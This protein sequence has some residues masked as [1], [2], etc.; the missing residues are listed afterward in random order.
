MN[1]GS[2]FSGIGGLEL[3]LERAGM[4]TVWQ[5]EVDPYASR[6]LAKHW[7]DVPN[8]GDVARVDWDAVERPDLICGGFPCQP[9]SVAGQRKGKDDER[10][11]WPEFATVPTPLTTTVPMILTE[12]RM[13]AL[14]ADMLA[15][16]G[17][18]QAEFARRV[19]VSV[20]HLNLV[21]NGKAVAR[22]QALDYWAFVLGYRFEVTLEK[23][24]NDGSACA[25]SEE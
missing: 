2:L 15:A 23:L 4:R 18:T 3:G 12:E 13:A 17:L 22:S 20:K 9:W 10:W 11:L 8:L 25:T 14:I 5:A 21:L 7:P 1:V 16:Q 6:V 24:L 19:G